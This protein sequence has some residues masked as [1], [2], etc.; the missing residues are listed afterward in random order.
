MGATAVISFAQYYVVLQ[1]PWTR[2][3]AGLFTSF[4]LSLSLPVLDGV[5]TMLLTDCKFNWRRTARPLRRSASW[6]SA[7]S[8]EPSPRLRPSLKRSSYSGG[9]TSTTSS[10]AMEAEAAARGPSTLRRSSSFPKSHMLARTFSLGDILA[11]KEALDLAEIEASCEQKVRAKR[12]FLQIILGFRV[13][14][15]LY[16][17]YT[18]FYDCQV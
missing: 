2:W 15:W 7:G 14:E 1:N 4:L 18:I 3:M 11:D 5:I 17:H 10:R 12:S 9:A 6:R 16:E 13:R 8:A